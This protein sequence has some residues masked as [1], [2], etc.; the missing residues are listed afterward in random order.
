MPA[1]YSSLQEKDYRKKK[2][3]FIT[4]IAFTQNIPT[5]D[6]SFSGKSSHPFYNKIFHVSESSC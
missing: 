4:F 2:N 5:I 6:G 3:G 1:S